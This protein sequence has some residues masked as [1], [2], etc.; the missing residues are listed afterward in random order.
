MKNKNTVDAGTIQW[1]HDIVDSL[2]SSSVANVE[3]VRRLHAVSKQI[4]SLADY[5]GRHEHVD[6]DQVW[7]QSMADKGVGRKC[8]PLFL[9]LT[10][11]DEKLVT[12]LASLPHLLIGGATGQG[13]SNLL[14]SI[15]CG[16]T[17]LL[18][19]DE[20]RLV[21]VDT[22]MVEFTPYAA[23]PHLAFPIITDDNKC[24]YVLRWLVAEMERRLKLFAS[25]ACRNIQAYRES[26]NALPYIVVIID[27]FADLML[28]YGK[29][30]E[31]GVA[32]LTAKARAAGIHLVMATQNADHDVLTAS[33]RNNFP[34]RIAFKTRSLSESRWIIDSPDA[35]IL[36]APGDMLVRQKDGT[37]V[38]AQC[39]Y[40]SAVEERKIIE[41]QTSRY[42]RPAYLDEI[43]DIVF[44]AEPK[45]PQDKPTDEELY[46][47][48]LEVVRTTKRASISHL[49]RQMGIGYNHAAHLIDLLEDRGIIGPGVGVQP[50]EIL[51]P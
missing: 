36:C 51:M 20:L 18:P 30:F 50:R 21:L 40:S 49:Q 41:E 3:M 2:A 38:R 23:L 47:R 37:L 42:P 15:I 33:L 31:P 44:P 22:K 26:G 39:A 35:D 19:P 10:S 27:E 13:K 1:L 32:R 12:D 9:G 7:P 8:L 4:T 46:K 14:N 16:L 17:R 25:T 28:S 45:P 34:G 11:T 5:L 43:P 24:L 48:A 29:D 6:F